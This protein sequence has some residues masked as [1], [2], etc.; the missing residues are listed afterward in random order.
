MVLSCEIVESPGGQ[1]KFIAGSIS[2]V[3][4][5]RSSSWT[6]PTIALHDWSALPSFGYEKRVPYRLSVLMTGQL[7]NNQQKNG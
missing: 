1:T 4:I 3:A 7:S 6:Y 2:I 5:F